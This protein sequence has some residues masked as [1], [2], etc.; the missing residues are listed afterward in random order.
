MDNE[1]SIG[2]GK[3]DGAATGKQTS[4]YSKGVPPRR[5]INFRMVQNVLLIWLDS[6][7]DDNNTDCR[8]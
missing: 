4:V 2:A 6:N 8:N 7:I 3:F 5:R 1:K